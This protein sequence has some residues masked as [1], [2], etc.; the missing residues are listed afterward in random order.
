MSSE[1]GFPCA[2][3]GEQRTGKF[4]LIHD[5][6]SEVWVS[7]RAWDEFVAKSREGKT[8]ITFK[9]LRIR[10]ASDLLAAN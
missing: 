1:D 6:N 2:W 7:E 3:S 9:V 5:H 10:A 8:F 4:L